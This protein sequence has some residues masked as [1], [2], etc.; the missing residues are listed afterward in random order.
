MPK[1]DGMVKWFNRTLKTMLSGFVNEHQTDLDVHLSYVMMAYQSAQHK[2]T[3]MTPNIL[4]LGRETATALNLMYE[5]R[6]K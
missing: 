3:G 1:A 6:Y 5:S 2:T 4:M